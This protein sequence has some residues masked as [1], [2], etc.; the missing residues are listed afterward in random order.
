MGRPAESGSS[1][2]S[3]C[4]FVAPATFPASFQNFD[5]CRD[6]E[7]QSTVARRWP[8]P[9]CKAVCTVATPRLVGQHFQ[10]QY[11]DTLTVHGTTAS[12]EDAVFFNQPSRHGQCLSIGNLHS[13]I[14]QFFSCFKICSRS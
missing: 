12:N 10:D 11:L 9:S 4:V 2:S 7:S 1:T 6:P 13:I 8:G 5:R 3:S 14:D